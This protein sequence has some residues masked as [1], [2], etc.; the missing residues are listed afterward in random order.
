[1]SRSGRGVNKSDKAITLYPFALISRH[2]T[3]TTLG[4]YILHE[5]LIGKFGRQELG[6][7]PPI[8]KSTTRRFCRSTPPMP[9]ASPINIGPRCWCRKPT[10]CVANF[11]RRACTAKTYQTDYLLDGQAIAPGATGT[12]TRAVPGAREVLVINDYEK[13]LNLHHFD[14]LIDWGWFYFITKPLFS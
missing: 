14:L 7:N 2:G 1:L 4:Y 10:P 6:R 13:K 3:P 12:A 11:R 9:A 8:R 5:G